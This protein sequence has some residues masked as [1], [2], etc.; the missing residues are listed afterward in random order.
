[1][2]S[3]V[4]DVKIVPGE[5]LRD[6]DSLTQ[7]ALRISASI[8]GRSLLD[9]VLGEARVGVAGACPGAGVADEALRCSDRKLVLVD[10]LERKGRVKLLGAANRDYVGRQIRIRLRSS[11]RI[12]AHAKVRRDGSFQTTA[13]IPPERVRFTNRARYR[14]EIKR[15][16]SLPL[17]LHRRMV[18]DGMTARD[19]KVTIAGRV[20]RPLAKPVRKITLK[21]RVSC[22]KMVV[23]KRFMPR[24]DGSFRVTVAAPKGQDAAVYRLQTRVRKHYTNPKTYPTFTLPR[25]VNLNKR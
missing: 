25:G 4:A 17:K 14:A 2:P 23:V 21:R 10:V 19:G 16:R 7:R 13:P 18:V 3:A 1:V 12:V 9:L 5:Q 11:N 8:A 6:G 20:I 24:R 22:R 15:E